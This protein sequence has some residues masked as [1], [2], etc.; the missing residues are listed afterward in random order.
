MERGGTTGAAEAERTFA[1]RLSRRP[2]GEPHGPYVA[3]LGGCETFAR[4]V[5][6]PFSARVEARIDLPC[7]NLASPHAGPEAFLADRGLMALA[8]GARAVVL[9]VPGAHAIRNPYYDVHRLRN[10]RVVRA[11]AALHGLFPDLDLFQHN[12]V[13]HLLGD[14][15]RTSPQRFATVRDALRAAWLDRMSALVAALDAPV[16]LLWFGARAPGALALGIEDEA[17]SFVTVDMLDRLAPRVAG[18]VQ[19]IHPPS[20]RRPG[21]HY[22]GGCAAP[23]LPGSVAHEQAGA[24]IARALAPILGACSA[25][26]TTRS[27]GPPA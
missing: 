24:R 20:A 4:H 15:H 17:P 13:R 12:Y 14:L 21:P 1:R 7:L 2:L 18:L 16:L 5:P 11:S 25:T 6:V 10:D 9:T 23:V 27:A 19:S 22:G 26:R 3:F 8:S